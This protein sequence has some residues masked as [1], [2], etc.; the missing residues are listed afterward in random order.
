M[1]PKREISIK[2][3]KVDD[4][5]WNGRIGNAVEKAV[6]Y[7]WRVLNDQEPGAVPSHAVINFKICAGLAEGKFGGFRFQ[8]SDL[9]KW[10]EAAAYSLLYKDSPE[11]RAALEEVV[12]VIEKAQQ[13]DGYLDTYFILEKPEERWRDIAHGHELYCAGHTL[14]AAVALFQVTGSSRLF[15]H[16]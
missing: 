3:I 5:F 15:H 1:A 12:S 13:P 14:E 8:D 2:D 16:L 4:S 7:Q 9:A 6:P 10:I 11:I